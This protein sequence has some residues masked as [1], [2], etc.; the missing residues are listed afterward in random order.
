MAHAAK[1]GTVNLQW[2]ICGT[3]AVGAQLS[4]DCSHVCR[5]DVQTSLDSSASEQLMDRVKHK[6][7][8]FLLNVLSVVL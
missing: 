7:S 5:L 3:P 2:S 6:P 1:V 4:F 8:P